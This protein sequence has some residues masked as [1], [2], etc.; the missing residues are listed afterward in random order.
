MKIIRQFISF[1]ILVLFLVM[2]GF[3]C[4]DKGYIQYEK[5]RF[6]YKDSL[7]ILAERLDNK[8]AELRNRAEALEKELQMKEEASTADLDS[9]KLRIT[10]LEMLQDRF[11]QAIGTVSEATIEEWEKTKSRVDNL[12]VEFQEEIPGSD[13]DYPSESRE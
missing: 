2:L 11:N 8:I 1:V 9:L 13:P 4:E 7:E 10:D 5:E 3:Q 12:M 6:I